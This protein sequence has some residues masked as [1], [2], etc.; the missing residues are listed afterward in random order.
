MIS[1]PLRFEQACGQKE[2]ERETARIAGAAIR[3]LIRMHHLFTTGVIK[4][5]KLLII[6]QKDT[7]MNLFV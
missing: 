1:S 6:F 4:P 2:G 5:T 7:K 3:H